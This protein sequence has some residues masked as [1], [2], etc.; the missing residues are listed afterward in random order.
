MKRFILFLTI[1]VL[2]FISTI[3][4]DACTGFIVTKGASTDG[5]VMVTYNADSYGMYGNMYSHKGGIHP[6]GEMRKI[7]DWDSRKYLGEIPQAEVTYNVVGQMNEHQVAVTETTFGGRLE[8]M[9]PKG[10]IDYGSLIYIALERS[11]TAREAIDVM[12]SLVEKYGYYSEGETFTVSDKNE[13]WVMEMIGKGPEQKGAVWVAVR[14]PDGYICAHAN[15]SRITK[16]HKLFPKENVLYSKDVIKFA[17]SKGFFSGKDEDFSFRDA[18]APNDFSAVRYCEAR[19]WSFFNHHVSGMDKYLDYIL[20]KDLSGEM[21]LYL[22]PD[23]KVSLQDIMSDMRDH[24]EGTP[25]DIT[26]DLGAGP[27]NMPYRPTPLS[28]KVGD[29]EVFNE[30]P[31][32]TQQTSFSFIGQMRSWMDDAVGGIVWW[33]NDDA[34][35]APYTPISCGSLNVPD[36]FVE[37]K[38]KQDGVTFSWE[39]AFWVQNT[40]ANYV[41]P[42]YSKIFPDVLR[43]RNKVESKF[44]ADVNEK[45]NKISATSRNELTDFS[46]KE[47]DIMMDEWKNLF[48]YIIVKHNDV[49][50]KQ[51]DENDNFK[52]TSDGN[53]EPTIRIG[54]SDKYWEKI[55]KETGDKY[56]LTPER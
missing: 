20:C 18:Y 29:K 46:R 45:L 31:I 6:K 17:K 22:K 27:W 52:R 15:Q 28:K 56:L 54:Y 48:A 38:D 49:V 16:F 4:I 21:P 53:V 43:Y 50:I 42:Y 34:N 35:M 23:K 44:I 14:V 1:C 12:T 33:T 10:G 47:A 55:L 7:Y 41:Y 32:S 39:S 19:V 11:K 40:V 8:L 25:L 37:Q 13:V 24:Y 26:D 3:D 9:D 36:C 51:V 5:S 30:R 2:S